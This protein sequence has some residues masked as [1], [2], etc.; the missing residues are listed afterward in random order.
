MR[1]KTPHF[2]IAAFFFCV[3]EYTHLAAEVV[4]RVYAPG[5]RAIDSV[6]S[7]AVLVAIILTGFMTVPWICR[8]TLRGYAALERVRRAVA[9]WGRAKLRKYM[10]GLLNRLGQ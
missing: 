9:A 4:K 7:T 6:S 3:A 10:E 2:F 5:S 8:K 1:N